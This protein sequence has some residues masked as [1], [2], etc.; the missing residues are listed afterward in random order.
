MANCFGSAAYWQ[1]RVYFIGVKDGLKM[2]TFSNGT[3]VNFSRMSRS[4]PKL[5]GYPGASPSI[6]A[7][8]ASQ[9]IVWAIEKASSGNAV[10]HA[11][12]ATNVASELYNSSQNASD[13]AGRA[14]KFATPTIASGKAYVGTQVVDRGVWLIDFLPQA[15]AP[16]FNLPGGS[17]NAPISVTISEWT[18]GTT[19]Y[20]T[21]DGTTP[22]TASKIYTGQIV[23]NA[24]ETLSAMAVGG[25]FRSSPVT[26]ANYVISGG[27]G[28]SIAFVQG[29]YADPSTTQNTVTVPFPQAQL[30]G[31]LNIVVV[32]W[33]DAQP[34]SRPAVS[35]IQRAIRTAARSRSNC[36]AR[37]RNAGY[38]LREKHPLPPLEQTA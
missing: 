7:N 11:Y 26:S 21:T 15:A 35:P 27:G 1:G 18:P 10:L 37:N 23:I 16:S 28:A 32:A 2:F 6:T 20:Y 5:Y 22:T 30:A 8:G 36:N 3:A 13:V 14:V 12:D 25:G 38:L 19:V 33:N 24:T 31:D 17:Y 34:P 29:T 9:G 4:L